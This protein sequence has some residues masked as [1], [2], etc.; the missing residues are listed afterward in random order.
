MTPARRLAVTLLALA[1]AAFGLWLATRL[2]WL[3]AAYQSPLR[4]SVTVQATGAQLRPELAAIALVAVAAAAAIVAT[5]G[6]ARRLVGVLVA[7]AGG[8][9]VWLSLAPGAAVPGSAGA[10]SAGSGS[11]TALDGPPA[12]AV[13]V[14]LPVHTAAPLLGVG[15]GLLLVAAAAGVVC[16][17]NAMPKLGARYAAPGAA[18]RVPDRDTQ[19]WDALDAGQDPTLKSPPADPGASR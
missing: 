18:R 14:G 9:A 11:G 2:V 6:W 5:S 15:A 3:R 17:A 16:W 19:W 8:W 4:G 13:S 10:R 1:L 7:A 12:D